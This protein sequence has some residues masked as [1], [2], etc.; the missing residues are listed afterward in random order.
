MI[1]KEEIDTLNQILTPLIC[2]QN[3]SIHQALLNNKNRIMFSD[4]S[5]YKYIDLPRKVRYRS[6][7]KPTTIYKIDK[8][9]LENRTYEDYVKYIKEDPDTPIVEMDS[10]EGKKV[11]KFYLLFI[12]LIAHLC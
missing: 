4:K 3:Q 11:V 2:E 7:T 5:I 9:C 10:V 8:K 6:R 1:Y 12:L